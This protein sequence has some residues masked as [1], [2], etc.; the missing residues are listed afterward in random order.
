V[1][2]S[3]ERRGRRPGVGPLSCIRTPGDGAQLQHHPA[4]HQERPHQRAA[5]R[6]PRMIRRAFERHRI[7]PPAQAPPKAVP[8]HAQADAEVRIRL[9]VAAEPMRLKPHRAPQ[10][11]HWT[12]PRRP[13]RRGLLQLQQGVVSKNNVDRIFFLLSFP[14]VPL[15]AVAVDTP[16]GSLRG[17]THMGRL[18]R[19][20]Q[21]PRIAARGGCSPRPSRRSRLRGGGDQRAVGRPRLQFRDAAHRCRHHSG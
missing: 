12:E 5:G 4:G 8:Q 6:P 14:R 7:F 21:A 20:A 1:S 10:V 13:K 11:S 3:S 18:P 19:K 17:R 15:A 9:A 16:R 2:L